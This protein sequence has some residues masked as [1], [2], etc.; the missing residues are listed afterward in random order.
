MHY[1][2]VLPFYSD[3]FLSFTYNETLIEGQAFDFC[4]GIFFNGSSLLP[5]GFVE[6]RVSVNPE[7]ATGILTRQI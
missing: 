2:S 6:L 3:V 5:N 7:S 4:V 1:T